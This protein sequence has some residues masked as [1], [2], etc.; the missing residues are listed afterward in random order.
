MTNRELVA[1][2]LKPRHRAPTEA[3]VDLFIA[4]CERTGLDPLARQI[5]G[6][7]R[8]DS[9][10]GR[11]TMAIQATID[12][13]RVVAER[14]GD[15]L[16]GDAP[17]WC[18]TDGVWRDVWLE[19]Q[20]AA[21]RITVHKSLSGHVGDT[22]V[23]AH[24]REYAPTGAAARMWTAMPSLMLAK[25]AEALAL[26]RAFPMVLSGLYTADEMAQV[27]PAPVEEIP[28][29]RT[30]DGERHSDDAP[31]TVVTD[32]MAVESLKLLCKVGKFNWAVI[33]E[34]YTAASLTPPAAFAGAFVAMTVEEV[35]ALA[36]ALRDRIIA[37]STDVPY[38]EAEVA[39]APPTDDSDVFIPSAGNGDGGAP[40]S[41]VAPD[42]AP[43][44]PIPLPVGDA[45][46]D[47]LLAA[48]QK[49]E[50][51]EELTAEERALLE[52]GEEVVAGALGEPAVEGELTEADLML[53]IAFRKGRGLVG[54][55]AVELGTTP[56]LAR[57]A[58]K[59]LK[60]RLSL[61]T[62]IALL[63]VAE[64]RTAEHAVVGADWGAA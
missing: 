9:K 11:E 18:G 7:Y 6:T 60:G 5:Y 55:T 10:S 58:V 40:G 13:F 1:G 30:Y 27:T 41:A 32:P 53:L 56:D 3:E 23:V 39:P 15:Y 26:R 24:W 4:T 21:A 45:P 8:T 46:V 50:R 12:G 64:R 63:E 44:E 36:T 16:G 19:G 17:Q 25:V 43:S 34:C 51:G 42:A 52:G 2:L 48:A 35:E 62:N 59:D 49:E 33:K 38:V 54:R 28:A 22:T 29:A 47:A 31:S 14:S 57:A 61:K 20:P 37:E